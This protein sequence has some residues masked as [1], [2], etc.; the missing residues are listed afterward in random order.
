MAHINIWTK[1]KK[2]YSASIREQDRP[3]NQSPG[4]GAGPD[5]QSEAR[6]AGP[7]DSC[8]SQFDDFVSVPF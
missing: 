7:D 8:S 6:G 5:D 2:L 1:K 4:G 3:T